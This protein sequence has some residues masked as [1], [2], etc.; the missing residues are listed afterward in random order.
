MPVK[1]HKTLIIFT[2]LLFFCCTLIRH[3]RWTFNLLSIWKRVGRR[4]PGRDW[5]NSSWLLWSGNKALKYPMII[6]WPKNLHYF[7]QKEGLAP[8]FNWKSKVT[9]PMITM[10]VSSVFPGGKF[11]D[12]DYSYQ[13]CALREAEEEIGINGS[14]V[15]IIG[16]LSSIYIPVSNFLIY[17]LLV[18]WETILNLP[19]NAMKRRTFFEIPLKHFLENRNKKMDLDVEGRLLKRCTFITTSTT[20]PWAPLLWSWVNLN[21]WSKKIIWFCSIVTKP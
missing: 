5:R 6:Y 21:K 12:T 15:G 18:L 19:F 14:D 1:R 13:D 16:G 7:S 2:C 9:T 10:Q 3:I 11:E 4:L 8:R 20:N 17:P